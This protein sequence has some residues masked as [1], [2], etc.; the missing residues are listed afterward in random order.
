M[1]S[2]DSDPESASTNVAEDAR[3]EQCLRALV[4]KTFASDADNLTL[5]RIRTKA[6][7]ELDLEDGY[8][9]ADAIWKTKSKDIV[10]DELV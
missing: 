3:I 1:A 8:L 7:A 2:S 5:K 4:I 10:A 6:E 9:K